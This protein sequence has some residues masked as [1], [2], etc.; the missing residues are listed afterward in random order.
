MCRKEFM[1]M[2]VFIWGTGKYGKLVKQSLTSECQLLGFI[3]SN[4]K[5][6]HTLFDGEDM[7][8]SPWEAL[9]MNYDI[10]VISAL[11]NE[12]ILDECRKYNVSDEKLIYE[13]NRFLTCSKSAIFIRRDW[14]INSMSWA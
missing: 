14:R 6:Q 1:I 2:R 11:R 13:R 5:K 4:I 7:I 10:I 8:Y 3:D 9:R 12:Q